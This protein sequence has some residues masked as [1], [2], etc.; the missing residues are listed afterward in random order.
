LHTDALAPAKLS[1]LERKLLDALQLYTLKLSDEMK[2]L[3]LQRQLMV[4]V[5]K[6]RKK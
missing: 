5:T 4:V 6:K 2:A 1:E 3:L